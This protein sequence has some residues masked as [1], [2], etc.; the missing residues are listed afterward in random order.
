[1]TN[2]GKSV[3]KPSTLGAIGILAR[4]LVEIQKWAKKLGV[5]AND[6][7][8]LRCPK[9]DL[10]EDVTAGGMLIVTKR[11]SRHTDT[12]LRFNVNLKTH[13]AICPACA[14]RFEWDEE[15][16][17]ANQKCL[18]NPAMRSFL[19]I[20]DCWGLSEKQEM[21]LLDVLDRS[22]YGRWKTGRVTRLP[23]GTMKRICH[24]QA[25]FSSLHILLK[26][27][28][29]DAWIK[30]PNTVQLFAGRSALERMLSGCFGDIL[31]VRRHLETQLV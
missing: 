29:A 26:G 20:S 31:A 7:E 16:T 8:I 17:V 22:V 28:A 2:R 24:L 12:G 6:R 1:M 14:T 19:D 5:F 13:R 30:K 11:G 25:I 23:V 18:P 21:I 10:E 27:E 3:K 4:Q 15:G 9:C